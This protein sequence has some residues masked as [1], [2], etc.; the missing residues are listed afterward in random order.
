M[1]ARDVRRRYDDGSLFHDIALLELATPSEL[2]PIALAPEAFPDGALA[3]VVGFGYTEDTSTDA[4]TTHSDCESFEYCDVHMVCDECFWCTFRDD[5]YNG[6][7]PRA[8]INGYGYGY[9]YGANGNDTIFDDIYNDDSPY[10]DND[11][12]SSGDDN[13][14]YYY[15][16]SSYYNDYY[17]YGAAGGQSCQCLAHSVCAEDEY[18]DIFYN[19]YAC[20]GCDIFDDAIDG[21]CPEKCD[22]FSTLSEDTVAASGGPVYPRADDD[23]GGVYYDDFSIGGCEGHEQCPDDEYC[24]AD[25]LCGSCHFCEYDGNAIEHE[26]STEVRCIREPDS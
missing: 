22:A 10:D 14:Y 9:S 2:P 20:D 4:C 16:N 13:N 24:D 5:A 18:C 8:C 11:Y 26:M 7:C 21:S 23:D 17:Y 6:E 25:G 3:D 15:S 1:P 19:C 12:Y